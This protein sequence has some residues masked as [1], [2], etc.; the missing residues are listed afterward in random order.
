VLNWLRQEP[1]APLAYAGVAEIWGWAMA[2][3]RPLKIAA[4]RE[5]RLP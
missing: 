5:V 2:N 3:W 4:Q 1:P